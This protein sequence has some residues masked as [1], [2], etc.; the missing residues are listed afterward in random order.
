MFQ[1]F[2]F[3]RKTESFLLLLSSYQSRSQRQILY[4][5]FK[6]LA[7][8]PFSFLTDIH[9]CVYIYQCILYYIWPGDRTQVKSSLSYQ[10]QTTN[11]EEIFEVQDKQS[12]FPLGWIHVSALLFLIGS[13]VVV[14][15]VS[16]P[17]LYYAYYLLFSF[18]P[19]C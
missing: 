1:I 8:F 19:L 17:N 18:Q 16:M 9:V 6:S 10:C 3:V 13:I 14:T 15:S 2:L 7:L 12:L 11:E 4:G 5:S